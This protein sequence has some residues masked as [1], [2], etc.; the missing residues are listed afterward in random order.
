MMVARLLGVKVAL[1]IVLTTTLLPSQV[2]IWAP[3][4]YDDGYIHLLIEM[5]PLRREMCIQEHLQLFAYSWSLWHSYGASS[6]PISGP[7][8]ICQITGS[9]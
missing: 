8:S 6:L 5:H 9:C 7:L 2:G 3:Y 4:N 1:G